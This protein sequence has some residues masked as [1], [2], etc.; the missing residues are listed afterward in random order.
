MDIQQSL[1]IDDATSEAQTGKQRVW[2]SRVRTVFLFLIAGI[3]CYGVYVFFS[4]DWKEVTVY[5]WN[6]KELLLVCFL[7]SACDVTTDGIIWTNVLRQHN[8]RLGVHRGLLLFLSGYA[9]Y[10]MPVQL[11][12]F[13][14]ATE[15]SRI[16]GVPMKTSITTEITLLCFIV[17]SNISIFF[18]A[19]ISRWF[20]PAGL[21]LPFVMIPVMLMVAQGV[22]NWIPRLLLDIPTGYWIKP[23]TMFLCLLSSLGWI[24]NGILLFLF[25]R[26]IT[27]GLHLYQTIMVATANLFVGASSGLPGG[28]GITETF[29]GS[30]LYWLSAPPEHLVIAVVAFRIATFWVWIPIGWIALVLNGRVYGPHKEQNLPYP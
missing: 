9:A 24:I 4:S 10:L 13:F 20:L 30:A 2:V 22:Y 11:G 27:E 21:L 29:I 7:L 6:R 15:L 23:F 1:S 12:R 5:W 17:A 16:Y 25:F 26:D 18:S 14:R 28:M 19:L 8:I 3:T